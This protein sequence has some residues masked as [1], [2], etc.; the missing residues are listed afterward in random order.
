MEGL[1]HV[2]T[3]V[4]DITSLLTAAAHVD[5]AAAEQAFFHTDSTVHYK[6]MLCTRDNYVTI[7]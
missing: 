5:S 7:I 6:I 2:I 3:N 4:W 1:S